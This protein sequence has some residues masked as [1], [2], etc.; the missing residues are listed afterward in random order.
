MAPKRKTASKRGY[1]GSAKRK[2]DD[3]D[4]AQLLTTRQTR[5]LLHG[6]SDMHIWRLL[7]LPAYKHLE[8]PRPVTINRRNYFRRKA[9]VD[10][11]ALQAAASPAAA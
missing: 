1:S 9:I 6:C 7:N 10:W 5:D 11:I 2:S 4:P 8:F 3:P